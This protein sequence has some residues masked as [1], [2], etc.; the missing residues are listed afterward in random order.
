MLDVIYHLRLIEMCLTR[1]PP[2]SAYCPGA[3]VKPWHCRKSGAP[4]RDDGRLF[5]LEYLCRISHLTAHFLTL[6]VSSLC[7][8]VVYS[9][10]PLYP[11]LLYPVF[12][13]VPAACCPWRDP[14]EYTFH[15]HLRDEMIKLFRLQFQAGVERCKKCSKDVSECTKDVLRAHF[16]CKLDKLSDAQVWT[17][18]LLL[19]FRTNSLNFV[20]YFCTKFEKQNH[21][22]MLFNALPQ[23][24][25][26]SPKSGASNLTRRNWSSFGIS[27]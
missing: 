9:G 25:G 16:Q 14:S 26:T 22:L 10:T 13:F 21:N 17:H 11:A 20:R 19:K 7:H 5:W 2:T 24:C 4:G 27:L 18:F 12:N 1:R 15:K 23:G 6:R 3:L 8:Y